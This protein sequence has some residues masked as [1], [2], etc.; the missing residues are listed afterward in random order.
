MAFGLAGDHACIERVINA[1]R[2]QPAGTNRAVAD[3]AGLALLEGFSA[4]AAGRPGR[5][6]DLMIDLC[7]QP[8]R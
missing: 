6:I 5:V 4:F 8:H 1:N 3:R 7:R 2:R